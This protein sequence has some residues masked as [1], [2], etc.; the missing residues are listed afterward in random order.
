MFESN[1]L[2]GFNID[3]MALGLCGIGIAGT[4]VASSGSNVA[5]R[6]RFRGEGAFVWVV[7]G[8]SSS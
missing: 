2:V 4:V 3:D 7:G 1:G 5:L 6:L 8:S